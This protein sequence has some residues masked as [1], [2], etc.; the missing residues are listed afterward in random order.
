M[1]WSLSTVLTAMHEDLEHKLGAVRS[2]FAHPGTV[3]DASE[4][5]W[6]EVLQSY[7]PKR[8]SAASA[9]VVDSDGQFSEQIDI[10]IFDRQYTPF[11]FNFAGKI[12]IPAEGVYGAFEA[13]Q[14]INGDH[15]AYAAEKV[16]T[17][18]RLK[19]TSLPIPHAGGTFDAKKPPDILGG[20]LTLTSNWSPPFGRPCRKALELTS[21]G[22]LDI[23]CV[24]AHGF[25]TKHADK[26]Y[27][28]YSGGKPAAGFL[29]ALI[30]Q[31]QMLATVPMIDMAAYAKWLS[32]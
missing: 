20:L 26:G 29:F 23:G 16:A 10:V 2:S 5:V 22:Q 11:I 12:L 8:Y 18:R 1:K 27:Q 28:F 3:G 21:E 19:R 4:T 30:G 17:V 24:A 9:H 15:I 25:F 14:A 32:K 13:K 31:L 7:L 6:L